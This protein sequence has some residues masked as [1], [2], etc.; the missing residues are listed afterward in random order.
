MIRTRYTVQKI[1]S[2][3]KEKSFGLK[4][5][6]LLIPFPY[7]RTSDI[8][9]AILALGKD[10][11]LIENTNYIVDGS[12]L[13][14]NEKSLGLNQASGLEVSVSITRNTNV[15]LAEFGPGHPLKADDL[16]HNFQQL[17][18]KIEESNSLITSSTVI[19]DDQPV[20]PYPGQH[21]LRTPFYREY[22]FDG[23]QWVQPQ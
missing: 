5:T 18:Y 21:W 14:I 22:I 6:D 9:V 2:S 16:N 23:D 17:L 1:R 3:D 19:S 10:T 11:L 4:Q 12:V 15:N 7:F 8:V 20:N 13:C